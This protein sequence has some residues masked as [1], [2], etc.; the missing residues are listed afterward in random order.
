MI[1]PSSNTKQSGCFVS[2]AERLHHESE[3]LSHGDIVIKLSCIFYSLLY[4]CFLLVC[5]K[6]GS[7]LNKSRL[8]CWIKFFT[9]LSF[10]IAG[11]DTAMMGAA[12]TADNSR[13]GM[14]GVA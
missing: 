14:R 12:G 11:V 6:C 3:M 7:S 2:S 4:Q 10:L 1:V 13:S 5:E 8:N 9:H